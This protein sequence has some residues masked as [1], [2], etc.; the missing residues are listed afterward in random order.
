MPRQK[1]LDP[2]VEMCLTLPESVKGWLDVT[3]WSTVENRVPSGAYKTFFCERIA[4]F[5]E[6]KA[7]DLH[8]LGFPLG[9]F[10]FGSEEVLRQVEERLKGETK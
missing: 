5:R 7:L 3:L 4:E 6:R 9:F 2:S 10:I 1:L 8:P